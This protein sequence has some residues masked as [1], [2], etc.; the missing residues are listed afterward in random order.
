MKTIEYKGWLISHN[1]K[2]IPTC[3][4]DYDAVHKDYD[5]PEDSRCISGS[6]VDNLKEEIDNWDC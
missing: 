2:P 6:S 3:M 5:G 4:Y 1:S